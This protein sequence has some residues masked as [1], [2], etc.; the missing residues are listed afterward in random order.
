M[1]ASATRFTAAEYLAL[2]AASETKHE[3]VNG[4]IVAMAGGSPAHNALSANTIVALARMVR[5]QGCLVLTSD[6]R[7]H[8]PATGL[9]TYPDV[10]VACGE[11]QYDD[12]TP[13][14]LLNPTCLVEVTSKTTEDFDRGSKFVHYQSIASLREYVVVSHRERRVDVY[15]RTDS[16]QWLITTY[17]APDAAI[18]LLYG[19]ATLTEIYANIDLAE[20]A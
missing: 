4:I 19:T 20:G 6:Q 14:S 9:Y 12:S 7:V 18:E 1:S 11:R 5:N 8:V 17:T 2:E 15:R 3:L 10:T 16:G 13:R